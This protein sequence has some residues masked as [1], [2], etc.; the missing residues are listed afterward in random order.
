MTA[1]TCRHLMSCNAAHKGAVIRFLA[2][3]SGV[4]LLALTCVI[5]PARSA[6]PVIPAIERTVT[7]DNSTGPAAGAISRDPVAH[8]H[9]LVK[10]AAGHSVAQLAEHARGLA[11]GKPR[12]IGNSDWYSLSVQGTGSPD[13]RLLAATA[14]GLPG[15]V[16]A[17]ADPVVSIN[18]TIPP[19]DP[20]YK[21]DPDPGTDCDYF[22]DPSCTAEDIVDQWGLFQVEAEA[23]WLSETGSPDVVIAVLDS[24]VDLDHDDLWGN[25]W[26]NPLEVGGAAGVDD[27]GNGKVDDL[28]GYDFAGNNVGSPNDDAASEDGN[29]DIFSLPEHQWVADGFAIPF[30]YR[31][32]GDA[33]VGDGIDN[34]LEYYPLAYTIDIG[35]FHGT[36][37]AGILGMMANNNHPTSGEPEGFAGVC[38]HC[39]IMPVRMINA[40]GDALGSDAAEAI[41][42]AVD[43]GADVINA[44]WG[45]APG[46]ATEAELQP[47]RDAIDYA[48]ANGVLVIAA[49]GNGGGAG[50]YFPASMPGVIAVGSSNWNDV[51]SDFSTYAQGSEVL[52]VTAPGE[53]IWTS[54]VTSAYD[55]WVLNDWLLFPE[56][57][58]EPHRPGEDNYNGGDG[59]S[60]AA[61][62]VSGYAGLILSRN[63]CATVDQVRSVIRDNAV[64]I[65][66]PGYDAQ[67][68][69]GRMRM[70]VPDLGC[71]SD[72]PPT[73]NITA[74]GQG[75]TVSGSLAITADAAD[76]LGVDQV[77]FF[78][79]GGSL[80][81]DA[82]G[83]DGWSQAWDSSAVADG[84]HG[85][86]ATAI[87][88]GGQ[89]AS[90]SIT[91]EVQNTSQVND[92]HVGD[93]DGERVDQPRGRWQANVEITVHDDSE[94]PVAGATVTGLWSDG[95]SGGGDCGPTDGAGRCSVSKGSLKSNV[96]SVTYSVTGVSSGAGDQ[97]LASAN[98]DSDGDSDGTSIAVPPPANAAP[99]VTISAPNDG[100]HFGAGVTIDFA[101]SAS[102]ID[103]NLYSA[104]AW[105]SNLDGPIGTGDTFSAV[106][107][108]GVHE[109]TATATDSDGAAGSTSIFISVGDLVAVHVSDL[110]DISQSAPHNR[111]D[112]RVQITVVDA[113]G[114]V[115]GALVTGA[116]SGG[117]NGAGQ[118]E[119]VTDSNGQCLVVKTNL[120][121]NV[122]SVTFTVTDITGAGLVYDGVSNAETNIV[123]PKP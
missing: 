29:P 75:Q 22:N 44:S 105:E 34:N 4:V 62:L 88:S 81:I 109:I 3:A 50:L 113:N 33:G 98:H 38:W 99:T 52:D 42:Y 76:D 68:G 70:V 19:T 39:R 10:I 121:N 36:A 117:A 65:G 54:G 73:V 77:E 119:A 25:I 17:V 64:D 31:F 49:S 120:K 2:A 116:W 8:G 114:P 24:G 80:G 6:D 61:P 83:A 9:I 59:T 27:D 69:Y 45:V 7:P 66:S 14:R 92:L 55:A 123:L 58:W 72:T 32:D 102:D 12:R 41:Y 91:V 89:T 26:N 53:L 106:L 21:D 74:P 107:N 40:E 90:D 20:Y 35:V 82:D 47:M 87:D 115:A 30:G 46:G 95:A 84:S 56:L 108:E 13:P 94:L 11:L 111:W 57:W 97:Y 37:V 1:H 28:Y 67:T 18:D 110:S 118:C 86:S 48:L 112:A 71:G 85:I 23:G 103:G 60:F 101:G 100:D 122:V 79:D 96:S 93:L 63:P 43:N 51:R 16:S 5:F 78:V 15:V 104:I